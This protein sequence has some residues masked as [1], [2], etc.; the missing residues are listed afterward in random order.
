MAE[1]SALRQRLAKLPDQ[2][3]VYLFADASGRLLYVG[4]ALSLRKRVGSYFR[5]TPALPPRIAHMMQQ[6]AD[7][8]VRLTAS[9]AEAL[10]LEA[11]LIKECKPR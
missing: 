2:P 5:T 8:D 9:E 6:V 11:Q 7:V 3:G 1:P 10:L 4:K